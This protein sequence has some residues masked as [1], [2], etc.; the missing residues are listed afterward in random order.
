MQDTIYLGDHALA[1]LTVA[2]NGE[3]MVKL[4]PGAHAG[5]GHGQAV[6]I[7]FRPEDCRALDP[8]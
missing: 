8:V 6:S 5:L 1:V 4:P 3:F 7:A 2:G